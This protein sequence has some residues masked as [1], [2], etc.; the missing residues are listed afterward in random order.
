M[1]GDGFVFNSDKSSSFDDCEFI[2]M[3][4]FKFLNWGHRCFSFHRQKIIIIKLAPSNRQK[5]ITSAGAWT[6][7]TRGAACDNEKIATKNKEYSTVCDKVG[8]EFS[9]VWFSFLIE[10]RANWIGEPMNTK[11]NEN[12]KNI[13]VKNNTAKV[14]SNSKWILV[15]GLAVVAGCN[16]GAKLDTDLQKASYAIG[17]QIGSNLKGQNIQVDTDVLA[18]SLKEA[19][20]GKPS[21]LK[22]EEMQ[23]ALMKLQETVMKKQ[24]EEGEKNKKDGE[25]FL[26]KN[27]TEANVKTTASGLQYVILTEGT[28]KTPAATDVVKAHYK[29]TLTNGEVFDSSYDRGEPAEF[30]LDGV[31]KG[32]TEGLQLL[33]VGGKMKLFIPPDLGYGPMPRPKIP[34]N[35]VLVFEVELLDIV[36]KEAG[37][38]APAK[39]DGKAPKA[40]K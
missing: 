16:K 30:P 11:T 19:V 37:H 4:G 9:F 15:A 39:P 10:P 3:L 35:S 1:D 34:A 14:V 22:P 28:G 6:A 31:I 23:A 27:K 18:A 38:A 20:E 26:A 21:R 5:P 25:A 29:G 12:A 24:S 36:K 17:Q 8:K 33:K 32:W 7:R 2:L 40:K 13:N